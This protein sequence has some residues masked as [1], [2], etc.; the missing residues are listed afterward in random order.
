MFVRWVSWITCDKAVTVRYVNR[1]EG[2]SKAH[3]EA[4]ICTERLGIHL[5]MI[6]KIILMPDILEA[7]L[8]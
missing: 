3:Y 6:F 4:L 8:L 5:F 2:P 1:V 7:N